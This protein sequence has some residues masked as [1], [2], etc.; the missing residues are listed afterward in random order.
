MEGAFTHFADVQGDMPFTL[1]QNQRFE[2]ALE[3]IRAQ[4][5]H[6]AAHAAASAAQLADGRLLHD[7]V[8]VGISMYGAE[9]HDLIGGLVPAQ[10]WTTYPVRI[11]TV[12]AGESIGYGRSFYTTRDSRIM[13]LPVGYGDGYRRAIS[14]KGC[15]LVRGRRALLWAGCAWTRSWW[16]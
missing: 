3:R 16:M 4:G 9:V 6:P 1:S 5:H 10:R 15:V 13:T 2:R 11:G 7:M 14:N 12:P 8:R